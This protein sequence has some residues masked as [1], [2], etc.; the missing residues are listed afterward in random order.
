MLSGSYFN[1]KKS[2]VMQD[3]PPLKIESYEV[4]NVFLSKSEIE[5]LQRDL[6]IF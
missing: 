5:K 4:F 1:L 2:G 3:I 6:L